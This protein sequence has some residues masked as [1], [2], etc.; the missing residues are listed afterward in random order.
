MSNLENLHTV[1]EEEAARI[2]GFSLPTMR[3]RRW[4]REPP[5]YLKIGRLVRYKVADLE[6]FL[7]S[8]RV[9]PRE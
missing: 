2:L 7:N 4:L 9:E 1:N 8:C 5:A 3:K 6:D